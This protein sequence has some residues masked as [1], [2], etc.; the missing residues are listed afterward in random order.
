MLRE[1]RWNP[2]SL[3]YLA[4]WLYRHRVPVLPRVLQLLMFFLFNS[5]VPYQ[6]RIG[7]D[8]VLAHG[9]MGI[10]LHPEVCIG[11]NV[12][13][14]QQVTIGGAGKHRVV[15]VIGDDVYIGVGAKIVGP[16]T[17]G[18]NCVVGAN[19]VVVKSV[20]SGCVVAGVPAPIL[21]RAS[22]LMILKTGKRMR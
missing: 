17:I 21:Q 20:P 9:S 12:F 4:N 16:V 18:N 6:A 22:T 15:P 2:V 7:S 10:V 19:A 13:I 14:G 11:R 5:V 8:C 3:Y 1:T